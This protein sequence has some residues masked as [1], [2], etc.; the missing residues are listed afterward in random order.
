[1]HAESQRQHLGSW[2]LDGSSED[3]VSIADG[4]K[5]CSQKNIILTDNSAF[6]DDMV[7]CA[8][9]ADV[10]VLCVGESHRRTGEAR[11]VAEL[12]LP[13]GQEQLIS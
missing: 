13:P 12:A 9:R 7:E 10:V 6:S 3:V 11:N 4:L 8:H 1:P 2:C 5:A